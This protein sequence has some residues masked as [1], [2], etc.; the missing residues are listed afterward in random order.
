MNT[1]SCSFAGL[2]P[3]K[4]KL[5]NCLH[6]SDAP[7]LTLTC[8]QAQY[9]RTAPLMISHDMIYIYMYIECVSKLGMLIFAPNIDWDGNQLFFGPASFDTIIGFLMLANSNLHY[10]TS[11]PIM[12][13]WLSSWFVGLGHEECL[14]E[15]RRNN[16]VGYSHIFQKKSLHLP[17]EPN[18]LVLSQLVYNALLGSS[19]RLQGERKALPLCRGGHKG[20]HEPCGRMQCLSSSHMRRGKELPGGYLRTIQ[21]NRMTNGSVERDY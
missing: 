4:K 14:I 6:N 9:L 21:V 7:L 16:L 5:C 17:H 11:P 2:Q 3:T 20:S 13:V 10:P 12:I 19:P 1:S 15:I 8:Q 18:P